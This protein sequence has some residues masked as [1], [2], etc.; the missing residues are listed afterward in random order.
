MIPFT[1]FCWKVVPYC[2]MGTKSRIKVVLY[3]PLDTDF[4]RYVL[5]D[6]IT[7]TIWTAYNLPRFSKSE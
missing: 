1:L 6:I 5:F 2:D 7:H 4:R 3:E